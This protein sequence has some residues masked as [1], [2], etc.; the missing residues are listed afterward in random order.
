MKRILLIVGCCLILALTNC[1]RKKS[2]SQANTAT[3]SSADK[4]L[5]AAVDP[6][7]ARVYL[8]QGKEHYKKDEDEQAAD[9][10][11][12]AI[13]A[14]PGLAEA[15]FQLGLAHDALGEK[16][17][18]EEAYKQAIIAYK[19]IIA[20]DPK[21]A[22]AHH[23][24]GETYAGLH[25][26][27]E[28]VRE[29][30]QATRLKTD[31]PAIYYDLGTALTKLA[32]YDEAAA[33][34]QKCLDIDPDFQRAQDPLEEAREGVQRIKMGRKYQEDQ[35]KKQKDEETKKQGATGS[36]SAAPRKSG[37]PW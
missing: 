19:K 4:S 2:A 29:Y 6:A 35:L 23:I 17:E 27:G 20:A 24:L 22:E 10:F 9:A 8:D 34:F 37:K 14:D 36:T 1:A 32:Q 26:Y 13:S 21:D 12:K 7:Q 5:S 30:R 28:A 33:A 11:K 3:S 25:L 31:D 15:Y 18:G 16:Q